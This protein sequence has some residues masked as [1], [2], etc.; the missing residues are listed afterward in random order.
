MSMQF[1][2]SDTFERVVIIIAPDG[3]KTPITFIFHYLPENE[4]DEIV[5]KSG[6][7]GLLDKV[8]KGWHPFKDAAKKTVKYTAANRQDMLDTGFIRN[9]AV[10]GFAQAIAGM[11]PGNSAP[12]LVPGRRSQRKRINGKSTKE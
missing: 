8:L 2:K 7:K 11:S 10:V 6:E 12:S 5:K 3:H 1:L 4:C 9:K